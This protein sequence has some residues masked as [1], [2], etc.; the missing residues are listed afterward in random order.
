MLAP[1]SGNL[2]RVSEPDDRNAADL[3]DEAPSDVAYKRERRTRRILSERRNVQFARAAVI[4][5]VAGLIAV[6]FQYAVFGVEELRFA[7]REELIA[8]SLPGWAILPLIGGVLGLFAGWIMHKYAPETS[9]S[10]IPHVKAVLLHMRELRWVRVLVVKFIGGVASLG[11]GLSLGREGP[12]VQ[13]GAAVGKGVANYLKIPKRQEGQ[14]IAGGAGAG[15]AAAFNAPLAGFLFVIEELQRELSPLTYGTA[16]IA[17]VCASIVARLLTGQLP[18][19]LVTQ[20]EAPPL[21]ALPLAV[22]VGLVVGVL[23]ALFNKGIVASVDLAKRVPKLKPKMRPAVIGMA[24]GLIGWFFPIVVG[25]GHHTAEKLLNGEFNAVSFLPMIAGLLVAK[26]LLTI[27]SYGTGA[28]GG[29]FAPM[30]LIGASAGLIMGQLG[31]TYFPSI[32]GAPSAFAVIGMAA[33]FSASVRAPLTAVVLIME[34]TANFEQLLALLLAC[35][36]AYWVAEHMHTKPIYEDLLSRDLKVDGELPPETGEPILLDLVVESGSP[37]DGREL[38]DSGLPN[39]CLIV[40]VKRAGQEIVPSGSTRLAPGD[41]LT[42][43]VSGSARSL[44]KDIDVLSRSR[45]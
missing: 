31:A 34:M 39:G 13:M 8:R 43:V 29:I 40:T 18:S 6:L 36:A 45:H 3:S 20:Y 21:S 22:A 14:L 32:M 24:A 9:G 2:E 11:A 23:G 7:F 1:S 30:L 5:V 33:F 10:G 37:L 38:K 41:E 25:S 4:G 27:A 17:S 15:L 35:F 26:F 16:L 28:P 19:F 42:L 44:I 12:T